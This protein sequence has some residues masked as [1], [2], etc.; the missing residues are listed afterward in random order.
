MTDAYR[1][2]M[3][4]FNAETNARTASLDSMKAGSASAGSP[5]S[6]TAWSTADAW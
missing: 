2:R 3:V 4:A 5:R 1:R 6:T